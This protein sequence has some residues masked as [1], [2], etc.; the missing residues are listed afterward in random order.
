MVAELLARPS[1]A[2]AAPAPGVADVGAGRL[3]L[4]FVVAGETYLAPTGAIRE[5]EEVRGITPV[6]NTPAWLLG[7]MNLRGS[8]VGLVDL[9]DFLGLARPSRPG[10]PE[11]AG[12]ALAE[13]LICADGEAMVALAVDAVSAIRPIADTEIL[14]LPERHAEGP[15]GAGSPATRYLVGLCRATGHAG[16]SELVGVLDLD[17][18]LRALDGDGGVAG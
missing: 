15:G 16:A 5:I 17:R 4:S 6:P 1:A 8:I 11:P 2:P 10:Q 12:P 14:P 3:Y 13:A 9:A 18:V 7:V